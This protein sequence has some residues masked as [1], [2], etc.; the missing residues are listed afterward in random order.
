MNEFSLTP[1]QADQL[2]ISHIRGLFRHGLPLEPFIERNPK[3]QR[4]R[5]ELVAAILYAWRRGQRQ[6]KTELAS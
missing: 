5:A 3:R 4:R 1:D 2:D 6:D